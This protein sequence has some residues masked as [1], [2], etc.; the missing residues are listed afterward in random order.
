MLGEN[1]GYIATEENE[2][3]DVLP[4]ATNHP[5]K[6]L[7]DIVGR[8][9]TSIQRDG[10][11]ANAQL[12]RVFLVSRQATVVTASLHCTNAEAAASGPVTKRLS[13]YTH[14][15]LSL[16]FQLF[17]NLIKPP[18]SLSVQSKAFFRDVRSNCQRVLPKSVHAFMPSPISSN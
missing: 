11:D 15:L 4:R 2:K 5:T 7:N 9:N 13:V 18:P 6:A 10:L 8:S 1:E 16:P 14:V 17:Q 12:R 3:R